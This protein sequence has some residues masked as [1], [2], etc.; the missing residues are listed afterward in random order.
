M[1]TYQTYKNDRSSHI[2]DVGDIISHLSAGTYIAFIKNSMKY[3]LCIKT[4]N[5]SNNNTEASITAKGIV[6][7]GGYNSI[8]G[9]NI[10]GSNHSIANYNLPAINVWGGTSESVSIPNWREELSASSYF[11]IYS[12]LKPLSL[13]NLFHTNSSNF[14]DDILEFCT[15]AEEEFNMIIRCFTGALETGSFTS[16]M[17]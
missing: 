15:L 11:A 17:F 4:I 13:Q 8:D 14:T 16:N 9:I 12:D 7:K 10:Q 6:W 2:R 1:N 5:T 3:V